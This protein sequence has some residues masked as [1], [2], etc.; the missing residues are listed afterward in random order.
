[1]SMKAMIW[2]WTVP[3]TPTQKLVL[4]KL[5][6]NANDDGMCWPSKRYMTEHT[7]LSAS[8]I[9]DAIRSLEEAGHVRIERRHGEGGVSLPNRYHLAVTQPQG[10]GADRGRGRQEPP[11]GAPD[12]PKPIIEPTNRTEE[13][14]PAAAGTP[15]TVG[16]AGKPTPIRYRWQG[17]I[18]RLNERDFNRWQESY[19]PLHLAANLEEIDAHLS[20]DATPAQRKG[21]FHYVSAIL[22]KRATAE[23]N[24]A[25]AP[26]KEA[27]PKRRNVMDAAPGESCYADLF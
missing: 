11:Q 5:A 14:M 1:M 8:A 4:L 25:A 12:N 20:S 26:A 19:H 13:I 7:G 18:I 9:K 2:A 10:A 21:W 17:R 15:S 23:R 16:D 22:S 27:G 3:A 24:K 6:D